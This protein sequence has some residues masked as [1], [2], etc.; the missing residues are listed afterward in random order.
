MKWIV[1]A[2]VTVIVLGE[3]A[4]PLGAQGRDIVYL[5][6]GASRTV[7][8]TIQSVT[9]DEIT[10]ETRNGAT[11]RITADEFERF[12]L[13]D[14]PPKM[15]GI[16]DRIRLG[17]LQQALDGL[18]D[19]KV[20][21]GARA[22]VTQDVEFYRAFATCRLAISGNADL[23]EAG[24]LMLAFAR[25]H[26]D[27]IHFYSASETLGDLAVAIGK[28]DNAAKYYD[29]LQQ[30]K[31]PGW[32]LRGNL[33]K[34]R[35]LQRMGDLQEAGRL[36]QQIAHDSDSAQPRMKSLAQ[37]G[38]ATTMAELGQAAAAVPILEDVILQNDPSDAE[39]F[40]RAHNALGA[41]YRQL[42]Q[43][44]DAVLAYLYVDTLFSRDADAHAEALYYLSQLWPQVNK[45]Q[46]AL[47]SREMLKSRYAG[48]DW[49]KK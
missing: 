14:D 17:Q 6:S 8:G 11:A 10:I 30:A 28:F 23:A 35:A 5:T 48:T 36:Y 21:D 31:S 41:C 47:K 18:A 9:A 4:P 39:L 25:R 45:P 7:S 29:Q 27:S 15:G 33:L 22:I 3:G 37:V 42:K 1:A 32:R 46:E 12:N 38:L 20:D 34:A 43:P 44:E 26:K 24:R 19:I 13:T 40:A 49:A 16:R 2:L